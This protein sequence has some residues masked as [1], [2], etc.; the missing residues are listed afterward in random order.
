[1]ILVTFLYSIFFVSINLFSIFLL[2]LGKLIFY[3]I[4]DND[5]PVGGV[6]GYSIQNLLIKLDVTDWLIQKIND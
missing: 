5:Y 2:S 6:S 3:H 1:M 4:L